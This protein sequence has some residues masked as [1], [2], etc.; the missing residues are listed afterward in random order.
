[1]STPSASGV[2]LGERLLLGLHDVGQRRVA[3]LVEPQVGGDR[4]PGSVSSSVSQAAIDLARHPHLAVGEFELRGEGSLRPAEQAGE[5]LAG[6]IAVVVDRLLAEDDEVGAFSST[7]RLQ[8]L[9]DGERLDGA[10]VFDQDGAVGA[11]GE[12]GAKRVLRL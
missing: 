9:G 1:M 8:D 6:L 10:S 2:D 11:H 7:T 5:H 4:P 3:R 12:R